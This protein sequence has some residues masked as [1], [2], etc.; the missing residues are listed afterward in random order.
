MIE[1]NPILRK[2]KKPRDIREILPHIEEKP[3]EY[4]Y[5][6]LDQTKFD[7]DSYKK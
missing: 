4:R 3:H 7:K 1:Y 2:T 6:L 5:Q